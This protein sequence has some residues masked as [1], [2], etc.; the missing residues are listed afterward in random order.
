[1]FVLQATILMAITA[2][3]H[4]QIAAADLMFGM[5]WDVILALADMPQL[6]KAIAKE[7]Q[8]GQDQDAVDTNLIAQ[9]VIFGMESLV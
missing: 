5:V 1:M 9:L 4:L 3:L 8:F 7:E 6:A 2:C